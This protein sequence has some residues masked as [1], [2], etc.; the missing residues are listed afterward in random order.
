SI[1]GRFLEH[2]RA[3]VFEHG[4][5]LEH[6]EASIGSADLMHRNLDRRVEAL[7]RLQD[8]QHIDEVRQLFDL[9]FAPTTAHFELDGQGTWTRVA[10]A[11]DESPL[12]DY[13]Q[14][15][16]RTHRKRWSRQ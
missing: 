11:D 8:P 16:Y 9:A 12:R 10:A 1:L 13:Q 6:A 5:E 4:P 3:Y 15:L 2:S 14:E 7:V